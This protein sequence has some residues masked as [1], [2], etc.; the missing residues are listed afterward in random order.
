MGKDTV[1][2]AK[3]W[4]I[5]EMLACDERAEFISMEPP[6][7]EDAWQANI[8]GRKATPKLW[9]DAY[10]AAWAKSANLAIVTFDSGFRSYPLPSL[11]L[12]TLS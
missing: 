3:A 10:L 8:A 2:P 11:E 7:L 5:W 9:M 4:R 6:G 12:L 1:T